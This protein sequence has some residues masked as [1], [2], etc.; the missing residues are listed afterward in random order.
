MP[1][2][3]GD[4][5]MATPALKNIQEN[6]PKGQIYIITSSVAYGLFA[7]DPSIK[8][9]FIDNSKKHFFRLKGIK[10][11]A[12]EIKRVVGAVDIAFSFQNNIPS[13]LL[14]RTMGAK[15]IYA[16]SRPFRDLLL[17]RAIKIDP[18]AHQAQIYN[19]IVNNSLHTEYET[20]HPYLFVS[21]TKKPA[22]KRLGINPG[23][24]YGSAKRWEP[25]KFAEVALALSEDYEVVIIGI[26]SE[27]DMAKKIEGVL[28]FN[29]VTNY[30]NL[31]GK[32][33][34][35]ELI[36]EIST[37]S[38]FITNDSGPMHIAGAFDV[39]TVAIFGSTNHLQTHQWKNPY[40]VIVRKDLDCAPCMKRSCPKTHHKCMK[41]ISP[42][43][44]IKEAKELFALSKKDAQD[45]PLD[46]GNTQNLF[47]LSEVQTQDKQNNNEHETKKQSTNQT[48][49]TTAKKQLKSTRRQGKIN[50]SKQ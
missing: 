42:K 15:E 12:L 7:Y 41:D 34:L 18:H 39:P 48:K 50:G 21:S 32:T 35:Y 36:T 2:W 26:K 24:T 8:K 46:D 40:N 37:F 31:V 29:G 10:K 6:F 5:V 44:I 22:Q 4:C 30:K 19:E 47:T 9:T 23:A 43:E 16:A 33:S 20:R 17:T 45:K 38:L 25:H 3:I 1:N 27:A 14:L 28:L 13:I 11:T 49:K